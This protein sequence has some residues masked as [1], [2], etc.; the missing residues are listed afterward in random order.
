MERITDKTFEKKCPLIKMKGY[1]ITGSNTL[2]M[3]LRKPFSLS[4]LDLIFICGG[5]KFNGQGCTPSASEDTATEII[6][7]VGPVATS[8]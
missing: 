3:S 8:N 1:R 5:C 4:V 7:K 6:A 2:G